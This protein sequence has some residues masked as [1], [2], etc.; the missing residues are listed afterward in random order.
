MKLRK[1]ILILLLSLVF[2]LLTSF[3]LSAADRGYAHPEFLISVEELSGN[4]DNENLVIIYLRNTAKYLFGHLPGS[5]KMWGDDFTNPDGW[6]SGLIATPEQFTT[7]VQEKGVNNDSEIV[8]YDDG[9]ALWASR[10]WFVFR[11]YGHDDVKIL[12]GG[13]DAWKSAGHNTR[14]L[15]T[16]VN[17]GNFQV[18]EVRNNWI[19]NTD[20]IAENLD[21]PKFMVLDTRSEAEYL[22]EDTNPGADRMGRVPNSIHIPWS[23]V[24]NEDNTFK[25]ADEIRNIYEEKGITEDKDVIATLCHTAVRGAHSYLALE[26]I[27]YENLKL[28]DESWVGWANREDLPIESN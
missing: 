19:I 16:S 23:V 14:M 10:L 27:G 3:T 11:V 5:V 1:K 17:Q 7:T 20:T 2:L 28:Y 21:N 26:M 4:M 18:K 12:E 15:P 22:G 9:N 8:V 25:T 13:Y 6:V 24:L